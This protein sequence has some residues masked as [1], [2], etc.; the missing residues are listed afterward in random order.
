[1]NANAQRAI[2]EWE[3]TH[4]RRK[5][6]TAV[7]GCFF[8]R[9]PMVLFH[10]EVDKIMPWSVQYAGSG[11]YFQTREEADE[12]IESLTHRKKRAEGWAN[13][14]GPRYKGKRDYTNTLRRRYLA[15]FL[16]ECTKNSLPEPPEEVSGDD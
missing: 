2:R 8:K 9:M 1:M 6:M 4:R 15:D 7:D 16:M 14:Y 13:T 12:Y 5:S 3:A 10:D 11:H